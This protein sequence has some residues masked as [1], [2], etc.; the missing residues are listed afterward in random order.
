MVA[1][2]RFKSLDPLEIEQIRSKVC[3]LLYLR[4]QNFKRSM[5]QIS[6]FSNPMSVRGPLEPTAWPSVMPGLVSS[7]G[8]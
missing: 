7:G 4:V 3:H 1:E 8:T 6:N 2:T 5:F